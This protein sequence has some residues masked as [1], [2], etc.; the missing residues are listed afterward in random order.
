MTKPLAGGEQ[1]VACAI[2]TDGNAA[3]AR[4]QRLL[5][6][7]VLMVALLGVLPLL[8]GY[9]FL[10]LGGWDLSVPLSTGP[11]GN[12]QI[13]QLIL[14]KALFDTGWI[15][16]IP[17]LGA[18]DIAHWQHNAAAQTSALHSVLM[19]GI[20]P[21]AGDAVRMQQL[22]YLLNF[23][24][25]CATAFGACRLL[26]VHRLPAF[27]AGLLFAFTSFRINAQF[28]VFLTSYFM[29]PL[30]LVTILWIMSGTFAAFVGSQPVAQTWQRTASALL[31]TRE[32]VLGLLFI[33]LMGLSD[34]YYAFFTLLLLGFCVVQRLALGDYRRPVSL[35][36]VGIYI[37]VLIAVALALSLPLEHFRNTHPAEFYP[38]G[39]IDSSLIKHPFEAEVY[40]SSL[41]LMIAPLGNHRIDA[42]AQ[43]GN[44]IIATSDAARSFKTGNPIVSL[45]TL[46]SLV[47][48]VALAF[49]AFPGLRPGPRSANGPAAPAG[50]VDADATARAQGDSVLSLVVL[51]FLGSIFGGIGT[52]VALVFPTIRAYDRFPLFLVFILLLAAA[53]WLTMVRARIA[54][55]R[56]WRVDALAVVVTILAIFDQVPGNAAHHDKAARDRFLAERDFVARIESALPVNAMVYQY[57]YGQ[58]LRNSRYGWGGFG[59]VRLYLHS[60]HLRWSNGGAKNSPGDDWNLRVSRLPFEQLLTEAEG[61]GFRGMVIDRTVVA[62]AELGDLQR[63]FRQRGYTVVEDPRSALAFVQLHDPGFQLFYDSDFRRPARVVVTNP[64]R[65]ASGEL[66]FIMLDAPFRR[67]VL[68][69][70]DGAH[71]TIVARDHP[72]LFA[73]GTEPDRGAGELPITPLTD[74]RGRLTCR[75]VRDERQG[76]TARRLEMQLENDSSF[77][78]M[79]GKG[80]LP[81]RLGMHLL[82]TDGT[83]LRWDDGFRVA[84]DGYI[85]RGTTR[86]IRMPVDALGAER[87]HSARSG[88]AEFA[89]VQ[90]GHAW[91]NA[92]GCKVVLW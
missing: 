90:D 67:Y 29:V 3:V 74:M 78:W 64:V 60:H 20:A 11:H 15:L 23:P 89:L 81:L 26:G 55:G 13:W 56:R 25:I 30:A 44:R 63:V 76:A 2:A 84:T 68:D 85:K 28:Y 83:M 91:F 36:P 6:M 75:L 65:L 66:P 21:F 42:L 49:V 5:L 69:H 45:G 57:P 38:N 52:L 54:P 10:E 92:I 86:I 48:L 32:F 87:L 33:L 46:G 80:P 7:V 88:I 35:L 59:H 18:P 61:T 71:A 73:D 12:D 8:I 14:S 41:K 70:S 43:A 53:R 4:L 72:E 37:A 22:Y 31:R 62:A 47:F 27:C 58:Y 82:R 1:D 39:I 16:D 24:L 79:L 40:N 51:V 77:D 9:G 19:R 17:A 50:Q 34:G